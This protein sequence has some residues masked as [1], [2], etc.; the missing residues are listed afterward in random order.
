MLHV[1]RI[2]MLFAFAGYTTAIMTEKFKGRL[3]VWITIT[4]GFGL[5]CDL[6]GT[7]VMFKVAIDRSSMS[8][9]YIL[10]FI[11]L[12]IM[13][14]HFIWAILAIKQIWQFEKYFSRCSLVAWLLWLLAFISGIPTVFNFIQKLF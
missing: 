11:A 9:H 5:L 7:S 12:G 4:F 13:S 2:F 10:G 8:P 14:L 3:N 6:A 1:G